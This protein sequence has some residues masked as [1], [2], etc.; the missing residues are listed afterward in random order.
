MLVF[1]AVVVAAV[2]V[3]LVVSSSSSSSSSPPPLGA[4]ALRRVWPK[5]LPRGGLVSVVIVAMCVCCLVGG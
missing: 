2:A 5:G 1:G 3:V 4:Y